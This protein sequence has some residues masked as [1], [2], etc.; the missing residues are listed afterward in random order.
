MSSEKKEVLLYSGGLD[1]F[2]TYQYLKKL[3]HK[4]DLVYFD[5][6]ARCCEAELQLFSNSLFKQVIGDVIVRDELYFKDI[7]QDDAFIPNRNV[8]A[9][10]CAQGLK[11][12]DTIYLGS[13]LS[14]RVNDNNKFVFNKI[15]ELL[16]HMYDKKVIV[17]SPFFNCHK[18][19]IMKYFVEDD[20]N[21]LFPQYNISVIAEKLTFSCYD[22]VYDGSEWK[23]CGC[24]PACFRKRV[25]FAYCGYFM[26]MVDNAEVRNMV[27]K[28]YDEAMSKIEL[29][30]IS[31]EFDDMLPRFQSTINY[32]NELKD[33]WSCKTLY[34]P[35]IKY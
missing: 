27:Q 7:E 16:S 19:D 23:E 14:D 5:S 18:C 20:W 29:N 33:Y 3:N 13:S 26:P 24:C 31:H 10:I 11:N 34:C 6:H 35:R 28:Y 8:L 12:Y 21:N 30:K 1:S 32:V 2:L 15:G 4:L 9:I 25:V 17:T 22:P